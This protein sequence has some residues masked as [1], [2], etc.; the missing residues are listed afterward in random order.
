MY[1]PCSENLNPYYTWQ[2]RI[3]LSKFLRRLFSS[4]IY[5]GN[6]RWQLKYLEVQWQHFW[7]LIQNGGFIIYLL[8]R[9]ELC[10][11]DSLSCM[12]LV[13]V[14]HK[15]RSWEVLRVEKMWLPCL[16]VLHIHH[17]WASGSPLA[18]LA[19]QTAGPAA[20]APPLKSPS[21]FCNSWARGV[22]LA[23]G[24]RA[25]ASAEHLLHRSRWRQERHV[26]QLQTLLLSED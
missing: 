5:E 17:H 16:W 24:G 4:A 26:C 9:A 2:P 12:F 25:P 23:L 7:S 20:T 13:R 10:F 15:R 18:L 11:P 21:S 6:L 1:G 22:C 19:E 8:G 14:G 3:F